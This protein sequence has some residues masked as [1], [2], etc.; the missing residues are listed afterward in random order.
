MEKKKSPREG[1]RKRHCDYLKA[2][3]ANLRREFF[4]RLGRNGRSV[5]EVIED[6]TR[7]PADRFYVNEDHAYRVMLERMRTG[8]DRGGKEPGETRKMK[9][10]TRDELFGEIRRRVE[11]LRKERPGMSLRDAVF[12]TVNSPAPS[13][14]LTASSIRTILTRRTSPA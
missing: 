1:T 8:N 13:F 9:A 4:K 5:K 6:I 10:R 3:D 12:D 2:R 14:Y 11:A 7:V